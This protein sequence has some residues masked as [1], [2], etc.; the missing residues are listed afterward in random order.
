[1]METMIV[2]KKV[3]MTRIFDQDGKAIAVSVVKVE[4]NLVIGF[5]K[6]ETNRVKIAAIKTKKLNKPDAGQL[7]GKTDDK[8]KVFKEFTTE[9]T[10]RV[11]DQITVGNFKAGDKINVIGTSKGKGFAGVIKRHNFSRGPETHGSDHHRK[12]GSI[13]SMFP[14]HVLKGQKMPGHLG[15]AR[16]TVQNLQ[17]EGVD[18]AEHIML[19]SGAVPGLRG[20]LLTIYK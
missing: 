1:M 13:G 4:P 17:V 19:I 3:G 8:L 18:K 16:V 7:K 11:G 20:S 2:G 12:P 15:N 5:T 14:Q 6:G 9:E 10:Y